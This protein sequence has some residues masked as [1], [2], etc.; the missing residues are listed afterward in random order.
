MGGTCP[1][2]P[3]VIYAH[4]TVVLKTVEAGAELR[5]PRQTARKWR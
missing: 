5:F 3:A 4:G 1:R 2:S